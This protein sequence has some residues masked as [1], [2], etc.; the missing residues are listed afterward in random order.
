MPMENRRTFISQ[1]VSIRV[2]ACSLCQLSCPSCPRTRG[3]T[4]KAIGSGFL[5]A[6]D[7]AAL[8]KKNR[9]IREVE[10][11]GY[12]EP[13]LNPELAD[14]FRI[15]AENGVSATIGSG[16]NLNCLDEKTA[17]ALVR[18]QV[19]RLTVSIDGAT[20][21]TYR[22]YR[23]GGALAAVL[24]NIKLINRYKAGSRSKYPALTWQFIGFGHNEHEIRAAGRRAKAL[25]MDFCVKLNHDG[26]Y[27]P[28][29]DRRRFRTVSGLGVADR[30]EYFSLRG[31][32][33]PPGVCGQLWRSPQVSWNG[34]VMG[35][36][37]NHWL[38]FGG[39]VFTGGLK[40]LN[41]PKM[42]YARRMLA[43]L[44]PPRGDIPCSSCAHY[45][46]MRKEG[47]W[48]DEQGGPDL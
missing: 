11:S 6:A 38:A 37:S 20:E 41:S 44:E 26:G 9:G 25:G 39:N 47:V 18:F 36:S 2:D 16:S 4:R 27:S 12:G 22:R 32:P 19:R 33:Y 13:F 43:G 29:R 7:Y 28:V 46:M 21:A 42:R 10:F 40:C 35:C 48:I 14:I 23:V 34:E 31:E 1:L 8:L 24:S 5:R 3:L 45:A 17:E 30:A 15:S